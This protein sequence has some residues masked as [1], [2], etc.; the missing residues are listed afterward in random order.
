MLARAVPRPMVWR[1]AAQ[2][3]QFSYSQDA[4]AAHLS[5]LSHCRT[6]PGAS[7][8]PAVL[9]SVHP[10]LRRTRFREQGDALEEQAGD[11]PVLSD[12]PSVHWRE[13]VLPDCGCPGQRR[14][15]HLSVPHSDSGH[16]HKKALWLSVP[17][18]LSWRR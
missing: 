13:E 16:T 18:A 6:T 1:Q 15:V 17:V 11:L 8:V 9:K 3:E 12:L 7:M 4:Q 10:R 14:D 5:R 2:L